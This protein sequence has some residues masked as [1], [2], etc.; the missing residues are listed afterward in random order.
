MFQTLLPKRLPVLGVAL[1]PAAM[2]LLLPSRGATADPTIQNLACAAMTGGP[3]W[4]LIAHSFA[5]WPCACGDPGHLSCDPGPS[6]GPG[7]FVWGPLS[8]T[9]AEDGRPSIFDG[10]GPP[11]PPHDPGAPQDL[12]FWTPE[13]SGKCGRAAGARLQRGSR[14]LDSPGGLVSLPLDPGQSRI[15]DAASLEA[16]SSAAGADTWE[17]DGSNR[18]ALLLGPQE[19]PQEGGCFDP[20]ETALSP[21]RE[22]SGVGG[23]THGLVDGD[24]KGSLGD[25]LLTCGQSGAAS[26]CR[27]GLFGAHDPSSPGTCPDP[28]GRECDPSCLP[29]PSTGPAASGSEEQP[30]TLTVKAGRPLRV[31]LD[32]RVKL[33]RIGE[34]VIGTLVEPLYSYDRI[35]VPAGTKVI[36]HVEKLESVSKW[37]RLRAILGGDFTPLRHAILQFD[38]LVLGDGTRI[39]IRTTVDDGSRNISLKVAGASE[40]KGKIA[41]AKEALARRVDQ[42]LAPLKEPGKIDRLKDMLLNRLPYHPQY[43]YR[44]TVYT[45][46]L[47]STLD[48]ERVTPTDRAPEGAPPEADAVLNARLLTSLDSAKT[49]RA[50][51]IRAVLTQ[52]LFS[53]DHRVILPEGT[54]LQGEVTFAKPAR[55]FHHNGQLRF[56]FES[57]QLPEQPPQ[58]L[59]AS[60]YSAQLSQDD[61]VA[62][63]EEGGTSVSDSKT[64]FVA[65]ALALLAA[66]AAMDHGDDHDALAGARPDVPHG[67]VGGRGLA[68]FFG[69]SILG[70]AMSQVSRPVAVVLGFV[71]AA[72]T[73]YGSLLG[74]GKEVVIPANTPIQLQMSPAS[75]AP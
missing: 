18:A 25:R 61:R 65:P 33:G 75:T 60:L 47:L 69:F 59:L 24:T 4:S 45:A 2:L 66:S 36:G 48:F 16:Q 54:E 31:A 52:P 50:T 53:Q 37:V 7:A 44:G 22:G 15:R 35:V 43:L 21:F 19:K 5:T 71:G 10:P 70:V 27:F 12:S 56:L 14:C 74:K 11:T 17:P 23:V 32:Q 72:R 73:V 13:G 49:L 39:P 51:A 6:I 3:A 38:A 55:R 67:N 41:R 64:R 57:V 40:K 42:E 30:I 46:E 20:A 1:F 62:I 9:V 34:P 29:A 8:S 26:P 63:D 58:K 28:G 68:G